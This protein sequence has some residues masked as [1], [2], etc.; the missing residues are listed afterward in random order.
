MAAYPPSAQTIDLSPA[1]VETGPQL[2]EDQACKV[3]VFVFASDHSNGQAYWEFRVLLRRM[4]GNSMTGIS[5][6]VTHSTSAAAAT[7]TATCAVV[8]GRI[9]VTCTGAL[10]VTVDW[11][12]TTDDVLCMS[13][14]FLG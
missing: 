4:I 6:L 5:A 12:P 8:N 2:E 1:E 13:G 11:L 14:E 10:G 9:T 3:G 7:W